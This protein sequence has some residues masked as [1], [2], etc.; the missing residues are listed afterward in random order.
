MR[1]VKSLEATKSTMI[2]L[3]AES[4]VFLGWR[5]IHTGLKKFKVWKKQVN[6]D[7]VCG[8]VTRKKMQLVT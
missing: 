1:G 3:G 5:T 6:K 2:S 7:D 4:R 8:E